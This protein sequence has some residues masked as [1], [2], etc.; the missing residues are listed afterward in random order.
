MCLESKQKLFS[1][2]YREANV[3]ELTNKIESDDL[4]DAGIPMHLISSYMS[5]GTSP[6]LF[7][8]QP[9]ILLSKVKIY[10]FTQN[11][12]SF[13]PNLVVPC[14]LSRIKTTDLVRRLD[15]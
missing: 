4:A 7:N 13:D 2:S 9:S 3:V 6:T 15:R 1:K 12:R 14:K 10:T 5:N 11:L 8:E